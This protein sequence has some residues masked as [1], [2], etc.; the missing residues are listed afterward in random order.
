MSARSFLTKTFICVSY[1]FGISNVPA[2]TAAIVKTNV[3]RIC[4]FRRIR[5][6]AISLS[7]MVLLFSIGCMD[8]HF[9]CRAALLL[10]VIVLAP[11][12]PEFSARKSYFRMNQPLWLISTDSLLDPNHPSAC[13]AAGLDSPA[14]FPA[15]HGA[16][17]ALYSE[18]GPRY[19]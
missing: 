16:K 17:L 18:P 7:E 13:E 9:V 10:D 1:C 3:A 12:R 5:I 11:A 6:A 8:A 2:T 15:R 14:H 19:F 4:H